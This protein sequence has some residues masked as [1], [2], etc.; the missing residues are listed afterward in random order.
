MSNVEAPYC[1]ACGYTFPN[2]WRKG[3]ASLQ[4]R[5]TT[6]KG[7]ITA[8]ACGLAAA[9]ITHAVSSLI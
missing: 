9:V 2:A 8:I 5:K 3:N 1:D 4:S 6:L 7:W